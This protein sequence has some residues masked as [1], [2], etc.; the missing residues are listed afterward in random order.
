ME[1]WRECGVIKAVPERTVYGE[2]PIGSEV[3]GV[4]ACMA[5]GVA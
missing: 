4:I 2:I 3:G 5:N 1:A